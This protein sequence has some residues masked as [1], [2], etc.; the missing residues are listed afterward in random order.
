VKL[1]ATSV[2]VATVNVL[3]GWLAES[4]RRG[5]DVDEEWNNDDD[6]AA[7]A[8]GMTMDG[9]GGPIASDAVGAAP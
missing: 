6:E 4:E 8:G 1:S 7:A 2:D 5:V 9:G 3:D